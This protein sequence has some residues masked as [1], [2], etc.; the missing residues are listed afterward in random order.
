[1]QYFREFFHSLFF[2]PIGDNAWLVAGVAAALLAIVVLVGPG[3]DRLPLRNRLKLALIRAAIVLL[4][5]FGMLRPTL[6]YFSPHRESA[7]L[8]LL[9]DQSRS[10]LVHDGLNNQTRWESV[11]ATLK[12][13][14]PALRNLADSEFEIKAYSFDAEIHPLEIKDG[15]LTLPDSPPGDETAIG[16]DLDD[17]LNQ[18]AGKRVLGIVV[19]TD[20]RQQALPPRDAPP[21][22]VAAKLRHQ[23]YPVFP[24]V[25]GRSGGL[26]GRQDV[27]VTE[28]PTPASV[29]VKTQMSIHGEISVAGFVNRAIP[30]RLFME[31]PDG[32]ME[33]IDEKKVTAK[34]D[35]QIVPVDFTYTPQTPGEF[36]LMMEAEPQPGE[37]VTTNNRQSS[38]VQVLKGG[39]RVLYI[40]GELR[41][42]QKFIRRSLDASRDIK[43]DSIRI[44]PHYKEETKPKD[45]KEMFSQGKYDVFILGDVDSR[46]FD[47]EELEQL[48]DAVSRGKG[49][50]MLGGFHT[51]GPGGYYDT[52]LADVLPVVMDR[53]ERDNLDP[54]YRTDVHL[55]G[56]VQMQ[57]TPRSLQHF[58]LALAA[59]V[60]ENKAAWAKLPP[61]EGANKFEKIKRD[62]VILAEANGKE[63]QPILVSQEFGRG[64]VIAF[65]GD[66]TWRWVM[67]GFEASHKRFWRQIVLWLARKDQM[68]QGNVWLRL[69]NTRYFPGN[70][71][72]F[73]AGA[74]TPQNEPVPDAEIKAEII[75]PDGKRVPVVTVRTEDHAT[76]SFRD[77]KQPGDY[78]IEVTATRPGEPPESAAARFIV[79]QQD[80][81]LDNP[82]ADRDSMT[83]V[84]K[85]SGGEVIE[86][87]QLPEWLAE[88]MQKTAYLEVKQETKVTLWD[89]WFFFAAVIVLLTLE[90]WLR[91]KWGL[92]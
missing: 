51:F 91:K 41:V 87:E 77:T 89:H 23:G 47:R 80:L 27:A 6:V 35:G 32:K 33:Q 50:I 43:V 52:P 58:A 8:I 62:A 9:I 92:V 15:K 11:V 59:G 38:I 2:Y 25:Y 7:T 48:K 44:D 16:A 79:S 1:M 24:V 5:A 88:L 76:G 63:D 21:Q 34:V 66:S 90:W 19:L 71:V 82:S 10:M 17:L 3:K 65:A 73:T 46:V 29:F 60:N 72:E 57:P 31:M 55:P 61:L 86:P 81:E 67:H 13:S 69:E 70:R 40:E 20:G 42:E 28:F 74:Q 78:K 36:K 22:D 83:A 75:R 56:P 37:L 18:E 84:A 85:S 45:M 53:F 30:V 14:V 39:L 49:L 26:G 68:N 4:I 12:D 64:R 54:P